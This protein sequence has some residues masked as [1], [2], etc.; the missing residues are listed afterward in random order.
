[1]FILGKVRDGEL[2]AARDEPRAPPAGLL[3]AG[4]EGLAALQEGH[5]GQDLQPGTVGGSSRVSDPD[6]RGSALV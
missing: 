1:L 3:H 6:P 4:A 2:N 5:G